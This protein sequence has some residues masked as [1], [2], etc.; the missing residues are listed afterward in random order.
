MCERGQAG[1]AV[2]ARDGFSLDGRARDLTSCAML[3]RFPADTG[4]LNELMR[5]LGLSVKAVAKAMDVTPRTVQRW[6]KTTAPRGALISLWWL[7]SHGYSAWDCEMHRR[8][9]LAGYVDA[10][11]K[12]LVMAR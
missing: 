6:R 9:Q 1:Q 11:G 2:R 12:A 8:W 3:N 7:S 5:D 10:A 4:T